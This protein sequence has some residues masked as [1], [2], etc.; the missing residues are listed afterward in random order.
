SV[1]PYATLRRSSVAPDATVVPAA[2]V[3][4]ALFAVTATVPAVIV[5]APVYVLAFDN[6]SVPVPCLTSDVAPAIASPAVCGIAPDE[7]R[8]SAPV[9][10][11]IVRRLTM[12]PAPAVIV[13][14]PFAVDR[15]KP[16]I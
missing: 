5:V 16:P 11:L 10:R 3:P 14:P 13:T 1:V 12:P 8:V 4:S 9:P 15:S 6:V 2:F 7:L